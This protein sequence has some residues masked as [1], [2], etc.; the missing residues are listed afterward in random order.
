MPRKYEHVKKYEKEIFEM[1]ARGKSN[2]EISEHFGIEMKQLKDL[3]CRH[4]RRNKKL[5]VGSVPSKSCLLYTSRC[6]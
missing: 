1:K 2:R 6:V 5:Q 3:I 4:N